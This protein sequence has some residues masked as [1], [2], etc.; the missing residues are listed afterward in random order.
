MHRTLHLSVLFLMC[1]A[2]L[3]ACK[4]VKNADPAEAGQ[5]EEA[6]TDEARMALLSRQIW[7]PK[8]LPA[9]AQLLA[10]LPDLRA[11]LAEDVDAASA[12]YGYKPEG[13]ASPWNFAVAGSGRVVETKMKSRAAKVEVDT[14][15]DGAADVTL[16]LGPIIRG[17]ALRD[18]MPFLSFSD[19]RDQIEFAKLAGG[20]NK[21][22]H[23]TIEI[24]TEDPI[25]QTVTFEGVYTFKDLES[26]PE[27]VPTSVTFGAP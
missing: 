8:V 26:R 1:F 17:T 14:D 2:A 18:A 3:N 5:A 24:P 12:Q 10:P 11:A 19:F 22:A 7:E 13:E 16:Q 6:Q 21:M 20:L 9:V 23:E 27:I 25:G 4:I 15:G